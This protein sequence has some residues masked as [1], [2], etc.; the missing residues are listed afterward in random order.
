M[1]KM[2]LIDFEK[3]EDSLKDAGFILHADW[4]EELAMQYNGDSD[5]LVSDFQSD[6]VHLIAGDVFDTEL[7]NEPHVD[8]FYKT[9]DGAEFTDR[10][11]AIEY[12]K[13]IKVKLLSFD[14]FMKDVGLNGDDI[15]YS[16]YK[17]IKKVLD[18]YSDEVGSFQVNGVDGYLDNAQK[19]KNGLLSPGFWF[20]K[21]QGFFNV[22]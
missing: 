19:V 2:Y 3:Y 13:S 20:I 9:S 16:E 18:S 7:S 10:S 8:T 4:V 1:V 5:D 15:T 12:Q 21:G 11:D 6:L 14:G 22:Y 17:Y